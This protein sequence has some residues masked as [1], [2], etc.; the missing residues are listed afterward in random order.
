MARVREH[1]AHESFSSP[2]MLA[3]APL[4]GLS[5][6]SRTNCTGNANFSILKQTAVGRLD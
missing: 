6:P 1:A 5:L 4:A 3:E 2:A